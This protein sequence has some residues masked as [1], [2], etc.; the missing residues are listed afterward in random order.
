MQRLFGP[1]CFRVAPIYAW[2]AWCCLV[3]PLTAQT[4][5]AFP[6][7]SPTGL[8]PTYPSSPANGFPP[9]TTAY[10][11]TSTYNPYAPTFRPSTAPTGGMESAYNSW[12]NWLSGNP[13]A[14]NSF[15]TPPAMPTGFGQPM[16]GQPM[17]GVPGSAYPSAGYPPTG[18]STNPTMSSPYGSVPFGA[19]S[20][21]PGMMPP[22]A[23]PPGAMPPGSMPPG[24]FPSSAY[25]S[26]NPP[27]MYPGTPSPYGYPPQGAAQPTWWYNTTS[28]IQTQSQEAMR[29]CQGT[30]FR[31]T[32]L[33]GNGD[34]SGVGP[35]EVASND[36]EFSVVFAFPK[37]LGGTQPWYLMPGYVQTLWAGPTVEGSDLPPNAFGA[38][39]DSACETDPKQTF[40]GELGMRIGV[41]SDFNAISTDSIR[42]QLKALARLRCTPNSTLRGGIY[43]IDRNRIKM[44]PAFGVLWVPNQD[45]RWDIFFPEPT[46]SHYLTT[47]GTT[48]V[49]W[50]L[51]GYYGGGAWTIEN[52]DGSDDNIDINDIR[53]MLGFET[54]RNDL[55]RQGFR[56]CFFEVGYAFNRELVYRFDT[57]A[58]ID[59]ND[60]LVFRAGFGY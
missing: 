45:T 51:T 3:A 57:D 4:A 53:I 44:L 32:Y 12:V 23:F 27:V 36:A 24:A 33:P 9:P 20:Y 21:P 46:F 26:A 34:F 25:P 49:W 54:G 13:T 48:D 1:E 42:Y 28:T 47:C 43:Y 35:Y 29:L 15:S 18:F 58:S 39:L 38:F 17:P 16:P 52:V 30:R 31:Y 8:P 19:T 11:P 41:F 5:P 7:T 55:L 40:G 14:A 2:L 10:P 60:S 56:S 37:C 50:Y 22:G 59:L 6:S